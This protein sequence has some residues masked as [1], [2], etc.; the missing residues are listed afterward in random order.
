MLGVSLRARWDAILISL[1]DKST[2][3]QI[4][5]VGVIHN[6]SRQ[7]VDKKKYNV[8]SVLRDAELYMWRYIRDD[9]TT[10]LEAG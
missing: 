10:A 5:M 7:F 4:I 2:R 1:I 8:I 6:C 9:C 3:F